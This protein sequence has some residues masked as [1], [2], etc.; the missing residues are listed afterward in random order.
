MNEI[1]N[2]TVTFGQLMLYSFV[3]S[4]VRYLI[5]KIIVARGKNA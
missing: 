3:Y 1:L 2:Q 4:V 5:E